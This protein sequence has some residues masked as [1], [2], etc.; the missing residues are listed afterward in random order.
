MDSAQ[1]IPFPQPQRQLGTAQITAIS[2][3][4]PTQCQL[5]HHPKSLK[6]ISVVDIPHQWQQ[7]ET[8]NILYNKN[9]AIIIGCEM[10][11]DNRFN[12]N[13]QLQDNKTNIKFGADIT[14]KETRHCIFLGKQSDIRLSTD[15]TKSELHFD[16][17][18]LDNDGLWCL[19][20]LGFKFYV[21]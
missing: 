3:G 13:V 15:Y 4:M 16:Y 10:Q 17:E 8:I 2:N 18:T 6:V 7:N 5:V 11:P 21:I 9:R 12:I 19:L 1:V 14:G 20:I